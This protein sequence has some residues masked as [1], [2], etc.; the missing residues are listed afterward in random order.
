MSSPGTLSTQ[1]RSATPHPGIPP[2]AGSHFP[3]VPL[4]LQTAA[5]PTVIPAKAGIHL[6][7]A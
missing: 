5:F 4:P 7:A 2:G 6:P 3:A 1:R